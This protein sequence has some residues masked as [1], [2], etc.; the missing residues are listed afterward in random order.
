MGVSTAS[1]VGSI[2]NE[3]VLRGTG[4]NRRWEGA[5]QRRTEERQAAHYEAFVA[6][7]KS[8]DVAGCSTKP[9][10]RISHRRVVECI[11]HL[12]MAMGRIQAA[13]VQ[14]QAKALPLEDRASLQQVLRQH[15][16]GLCIKGST[17]VDGEEAFRLFGAWE[18]ICEVLRP[19]KATRQAVLGM[20][21][22]LSAL[23]VSFQDPYPPQCAPVARAYRKAICPDSKG[24]YLLFLEEDCQHVLADIYPYGMAMFSGDV[25]ESLNR[26]LKKGFNDHSDRG[27]Q[28]RDGLEGLIDARG[29]RR[30]V[31]NGKYVPEI[32]L[33]FAF[34]YPSRS[35]QPR[36]DLLVVQVFK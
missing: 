3:A 17:S 22:L 25:V 11:L 27:A 13:W 24:H 21:A 14:L 33:D 8:L 12:A 18:D 20:R 19:C 36:V 34:F 7:A 26:L 6:G 5:G 29:R 35:H 10:L 28:L 32:S 31:F 16:T 30:C 1:Q 9:L 23:Y 2:H 4:K 15:K